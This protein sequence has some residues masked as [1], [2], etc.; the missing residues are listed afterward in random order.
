MRLALPLLALLLTVGAAAQ[1]PASPPPG[2]HSPNVASALHRPEQPERGEGV[3]IVL[4][5]RSTENVTKVTMIHC[6]VQGYACAPA[7]QMPRGAGNEYTGRIPWD[8]GFFQGVTTVGYQFQIH[9]ANGSLEQS[10]IDHVPARP[11][12]LPDGGSVYYY[13]T[14]AP[15][16]SPSAPLWALLAAAALLLLLP[17]GKG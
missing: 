8:G 13:Y 10:P 6:R 15:A 4:A 16:S 3:L 2:P 17:R 12:D 1:S 7:S 5:L 9:Y 14:L 11:K